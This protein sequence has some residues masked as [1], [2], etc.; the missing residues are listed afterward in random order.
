MTETVTT[1]PKDTETLLKLIT[2]SCRH[3]EDRVDSLHGYKE[4]PEELKTWWKKYQV[5]ESQRLAREQKAKEEEEARSKQE[6][7]RRRRDDLRA[8]VIRKMT[9]EEY[10]LFGRL[11][12]S[13]AG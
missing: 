5:E 1:V 10:E 9:D 8:S 6:H 2:Q 11:L 13:E 12:R 3:L 7:E 4:W